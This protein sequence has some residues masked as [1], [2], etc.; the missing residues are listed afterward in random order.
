M[1]TVYLSRSTSPPPGPNPSPPP[2]PPPCNPYTA[3]SY[4]YPKAKYR[5]LGLKFFC[6]SKMAV[7][8]RRKRIQPWTKIRAASP[9][10][11]LAFERVKSTFKALFKKW[12]SWIRRCCFHGF[13][14]PKGDVTTKLTMYNNSQTCK[15]NKNTK[16]W[17]SFNFQNIIRRSPRL[18]QQRIERFNQPSKKKYEI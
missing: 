1:P 6:C 13:L 9:W 11:D 15:H 10:R 14:P 7:T 12:L 16:F 18:H 17:F 5:T 8:R 2:G 4:R 3:I